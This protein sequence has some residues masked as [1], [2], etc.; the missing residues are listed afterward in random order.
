MQAALVK[1]IEMIF[2]F[3]NMAAKLRNEVK[4]QQKNLLRNC[5]SFL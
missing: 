1:T 3:V 2:H 4:Q 5:Q